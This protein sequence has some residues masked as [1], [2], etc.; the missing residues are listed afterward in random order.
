MVSVIASLAGR[1][2]LAPLASLWRWL[3]RRV[4]SAIIDNVPVNGVKQ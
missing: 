1:F 2:I 3:T 4:L